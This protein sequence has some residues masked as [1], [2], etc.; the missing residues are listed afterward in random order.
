MKKRVLP[1]IFI[2]CLFLVLILETVYIFISKNNDDVVNCGETNNKNSVVTYEI[3]THEYFSEKREDSRYIIDN[4]DELDAFYKVYSNEINVDRNLLTNNIIFVDVREV[5]SGSI[6]MKLTSVSLINNRVKFNVKMVTPEIGTAD[7]ACWYLIA[8][9]PKDEIEGFNLDDWNRASEEI[10]EIE[11]TYEFVLNNVN[12]YV[13]T[14]DMRWNTMQND[15]G[16]NTSIYYQIDLDDKVVKKIEE[17]YKA[18]LSG[19]PTT[20]YDLLYEVNINDE[21]GSEIKNILD[22]ILVKEDIQDNNYSFYTIETFNNS[23]DIYN[24]D[25]INDINVLLEKIDNLE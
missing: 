18:N 17:K 23:R 4:E 20:T 12:K 15:G 5:S 9:I 19:I 22:N 1:I 3:Q 13:V 16:S 14:T 25:T 10:K 8:I 11:E 7:M 6:S 2:I 21:L 24:V